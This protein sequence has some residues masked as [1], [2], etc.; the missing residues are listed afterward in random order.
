MTRRRSDAEGGFAMIFTIFLI[1]MITVTSV[2]VADLMLSQVKPTGLAKKEIRTVDAASAGMQV[3]LGQLRNTM[4]SGYGDLTLL[5]CSDPAD[6]GGVTIYT[7]SPAQA[8]TVPG[9]TIN[10]T[11]LTMTNSADTEAYKTVVTYF[12]TDPTSHEN[13]AST[14]W[15]T[16]NAIGCKAGVVKS[17]PSYAFL[18]SFGSAAGVTGLSTTEGDRALHAVY[19][20]RTTTS[21][22][23]GG[24]ISEYNA[25]NQ[26]SLCLDAGSNPTIGTVPTMQPCQALG[27]PSQTW[28]YR[29]DLSVFYG[30]NTMLNLCIQM[31][32]GTANGS[33]SSL[34]YTGGTPTLE[35]CSGT[36]TGATYP[37]SPATQQLQEWGFNDNGHL[38]APIGGGDVEEGSGGACLEPSGA[39]S[40]TPAA[41][42]ASLVISSCDTATTGD[43]A[44]DPDP[45]VGAGSALV[46]YTG[47]SG[48]T[49]P[50]GVPASS[51]TSQ[52][53]NFSEF[54]RCLDVTG[55]NP[56]ADHLIDY[57]CKQAPSFC[58]LTWNQVWT[59]TTSGSYGTAS[60][61][62]NYGEFISDYGSGRHA[63]DAVGTNYCLTAPTTGASTNYIT[64]TPCG[65]TPTS[66]QLWDATGLQQTYAASYLL[67]NKATGMCM[68]ADPSIQ[69]T[70][71]SSTIV[72]TSCAGTGVPSSASTKDSLLLKWN[73]PPNIATAGLNN[74]QEDGG[75]VSQLG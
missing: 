56:N 44:W 28:Q 6:Q 57:P 51:A 48:Q 59:F 19:Q 10:G 29:N 15:W 72:A 40:T 63:C 14:S 37:Y 35:T 27:T 60:D 33:G 32:G 50:L 41:T 25:A 66:Y 22:T 68:A 46:Y 47:A 9:D 16:N 2:A 26:F 69:P 8:I 61:N 54:G 7:G 53:V 71:G 58:K 20:F 18:Q 21:F 64:I 49:S 30:G 13:D 36:G 74:I 62:N 24:R 34:Y 12:A 73:A 45:Q 1:L 17:T 39:T 67:V 65:T 70:F 3:A 42:G 31:V 55:Q 4:T 11:V 5:P 23:V 75:S 43:T 52:Y 38:S